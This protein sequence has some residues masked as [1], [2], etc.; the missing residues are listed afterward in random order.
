M[1]AFGLWPML[2]VVVGIQGLLGWLPARRDMEAARP[3]LSWLLIGSGVLLLP[4]TT[5]LADVRL[6]FVPVVL[7]ALGFVWLWRRWQRTPPGSND[8]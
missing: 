3:G 4:L 7:I 8:R 1:S 2:L 5:G 6:I